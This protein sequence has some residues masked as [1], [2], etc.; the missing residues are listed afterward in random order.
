MKGRSSDI[1]VEQER[2]DKS[3]GRKGSSL[4]RR[5]LKEW[6]KR[7]CS[8]LN[9]HNLSGEK[10]ERS[11]RWGEKGTLLMISHNQPDLMLKGGRIFFLGKEKGGRRNGVRGGR[12]TGKR[13]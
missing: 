10:K 6:L 7:G 8:F 3:E 4:N 13:S 9:L 5:C 11:T 1:F 2:E 12:V